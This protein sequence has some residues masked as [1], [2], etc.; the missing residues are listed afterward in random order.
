MDPDTVLVQE[1]K[2]ATD[3]KDETQVRLETAIQ[4]VMDCVGLKDDPR[5][6]AYK[7]LGV[8]D[9]SSLNQAKLHLAATMVAK[10]GRKYLAEYTEK[11]LT[12]AMLTAVETEDAAFVDQMAARHEAVSTRAGATRARIVFANGLYRQL[13]AL[14]NAGQATWR[15]SNAQ[16]AHEYVLD[17]TPAAAVPVAAKA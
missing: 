14:A 4:A 16:K 11:G 8:S 13:V 2:V 5:T 3:T 10:Q 6:A 1:A 9:V 7:R 12:A 17:A 15:L